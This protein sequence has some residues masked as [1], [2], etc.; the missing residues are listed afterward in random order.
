MKKLEILTHNQDGIP[1][2]N[3][4]LTI[5]INRISIKVGTPD[6]GDREKQ[7]MF[8]CFWKIAEEFKDTEY[9]LRGKW[10]KCTDS[11]KY[12]IT[13]TTDEK[14]DNHKIKKTFYFEM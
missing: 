9:S 6:Y 4:K 2:K 13:M 8:A 5:A 3:S 14:G 10:Y 12:T 7:F 1:Y 11:D